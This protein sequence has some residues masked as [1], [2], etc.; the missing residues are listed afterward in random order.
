MPSL[1]ALKQFKTSLRAVGNETS[2]LTAQGIPVNDMDVPDGTRPAPE[3]SESNGMDS[4]TAPDENTPFPL[5]N[6]DDISFPDLGNGGWPT[7]EEPSDNSGGIDL[8][9][10]AEEE[11]EKKEEKNDS[12]A[13]EELSDDTGAFDLSSLGDLGDDLPPPEEFAATP[14]PEE[15][16]GNTGAFDLSGLSDL[17]DDLPPPEDFAATP[18]PEEPSDDTGAFDLSSLGDLGDD[19]PPPEDFAAAPASDEP[20]GDTGGFDQSGDDLPPPEEPEDNDQPAPESL[21]TFHLDSASLSNDFKVDEPA[22]VSAFDFSDS[23]EFGSSA[24]DDLLKQYGDDLAA[25]SEDVEEILLSDDDFAKLQ[26]TLS[27]YPLNVRIACEEIIAEHIIAP[28][29]LAKLVKM[30]VRGASARDSADFAEKILKR[31][32]DIPKGFAKRTGDALEAEKAGFTYIFTHKVLPVLRIALLIAA[33]AASAL[34]LLYRFVYMPVHADSIYKK[35]YN[36]LQAGDYTQ[37]NEQFKTAGS[38]HRIKKWYYRYAE[39]FRNDRHYLM[40]E[41]KYDELLRYYP[42]D[43]KGVLNYAAMETYYLQNYQKADGLLRRNLLDY[44]VNDKEGLLAT[45]DNSLLWGDIEP[46][47]YDEA[48]EAFARYIERH[49]RT[50]PVL[51]RMLEYFIRVDNLKEVLD[52]Q[53]YFMAPTERRKIS[54]LALSDMGGYLLDKKLED[55]RGVP[56]EYISSIDSLRDII[57]KANKADP[58]LPEPYYHLARYYRHFDNIDSERIALED[59]IKAFEST[60]QESVRRTKAHIDTQYRY[61]ELLIRQREFFAAEEQLVKGVNRYEDAV[62]RH[63]ITRSASFGRLYADLGDLEYFTKDG[64]MEMALRFYNQSEQNGWAPPEIQYRM[65]VAHYHLQNWAPALEHIFTASAD[66]PYNRRILHALGNTA[67]LR[68]DYFAAQGYYSRLITMLE[69]DRARFPQLMP[70]ER[71][72]QFELV[73]RLMVARNNMGVVLESLAD[74]SGNA[75]YRSHAQGLYVESARA[76][77][78]LTRDPETLARSSGTNLA[79]LNSR[80]MLYPDSSYR[81]QIYTQIDKDVLEPSE[82]EYLTSQDSQSLVPVR[83]YR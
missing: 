55:V 30:L 23:D 68:G 77:D 47:R 72:D 61:G 70:Q 69:S 65:G 60:Q 1:K 42:R 52:L 20:S 35:G 58:S 48:R 15:P 4:G 16:S 67:V 12:P 13:P 71:P 9:D 24:V 18:P 75:D 28:D 17:G 56:D 76:W 53:T 38:I 59:A 36:Q 3:V 51:E 31:A 32:I 80:N 7:P 83:Q 10:L 25:P 78:T 5:D 26:K 27:G 74:R 11:K 22:P 37:A 33:V 81:P 19:L 57:L 45:G 2:V 54:L 14:A 44:S 29:I 43:K 8:P 21:S 82:W 49:G 66:M 50:D 6:L 62:K 40:A 64:N 79:S 39:A 63:T 34:Y 41:E 73:E 46:E